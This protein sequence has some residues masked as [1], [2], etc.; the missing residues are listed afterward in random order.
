LISYRKKQM[1]KFFIHHRSNS[2]LHISTASVLTLL[3]ETHN[4]R[5]YTETRVS[6]HTRLINKYL[7]GLMYYIFLLTID[8]VNENAKLKFFSILLS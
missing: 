6:K 4:K 2:S 7:H 5:Q 1:E 8:Y 3:T